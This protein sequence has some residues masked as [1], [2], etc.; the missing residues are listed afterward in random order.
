MKYQLALEASRYQAFAQKMPL[1]YAAATVLVLSKVVV[2]YGV[3]PV[4]FSVVLPCAVAAF[5][6]VRGLRWLRLRQMKVSEEEASRALQRVTILLTGACWITAVTDLVLYSYGGPEERRFIQFVMMGEGGCVFFFLMHLRGAALLMAAGTLLPSLILYA[7][8]GTLWDWAIAVNLAVIG[9]AM[10]IVMLSYERDYVSMARSHVDMK[11]LSEENARLAS[12]DMVTELPNRREFFRELK[13]EVDLANAARAQFSIGIVDL[14]GFKLVNDTH[15]HKFGDI[16]LARV[17]TRLQ[18]CVGDGA[19]FYRLGGDE[20]AFIR[21]GNAS[22]ED[23]L[24]MGESIIAHVLVPLTVG[25]VTTA[26]GCSIG[27]ARFPQAATSGDLLYEFCDYALYD[28]KRGGRR[29]PVVFDEQHRKIMQEQGATEQ[30]LRSADFDKELYPVFQPITDSRSDRT[31]A[32]ECLA[33]WESPTL[34]FVSPAKFIPVAEQCGLISIITKV[35]LRK[36]LEAMRDWEDDI[37]LSFNLSPHDI[38]NDALVLELF[39]IIEKSGIRP[40]RIG[41]ELTETALIQSFDAARRNIEL[42]QMS[43]IGVALDDFGAGYS[44][45]SHVH[46]L[47]LDKLKIDRRFIVDVEHNE[48]S[49]NIIRSVVGLCQ[50]LDIE[51]IVEGAETQAQV[52]ALAE[53]GCN[54]IQGYFYSRPLTTSQLQDY[55]AAREGRGPLAAVA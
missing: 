6:V 38:A 24:A 54:F 37:K 2:F 12:I 14:D 9:L 25:S 40:S 43:G 1:F 36:A 16:V 51:C 8:A 13:R 26:V 46:A 49:R 19:K 29:R 55:V 30:A 15:G 22:E 39:S 20:F 34:G 52:D 11:E 23:L 18:E 53:L 17:A 28:A 31:V 45:L 35:M 32:Y 41:F 4:F 42:L 3:A 7:F 10:T 33:R 44:S 21:K 50:D 27:M 48:T 47:P 5:A